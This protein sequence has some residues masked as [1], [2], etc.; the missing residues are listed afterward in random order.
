MN[1]IFLDVDGVLNSEKFANKM[2]EEE[3]SL[4]DADNKEE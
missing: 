3:G 1:L 2:L 4:T